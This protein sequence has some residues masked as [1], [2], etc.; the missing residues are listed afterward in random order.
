MITFLAPLIAK[1]ALQ[2]GPAEFF[3]VFFLTFA[4]FVGMGKGSP[5]KVLASMCLGF[6][7]GSVGLD[8]MTGT[9]RMTFGHERAAGRLRLPDRRHRPVR[10]R[11]DPVRRWRAASSSPG[12]AAKIRL[13]AVLQTW[14]KL[15]DATG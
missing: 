14:K 11:R 15:P 6:A 12:S 10:H 3:S 8:K 5:F 7:L 9:L 4:S 1:F 13:N 2:F